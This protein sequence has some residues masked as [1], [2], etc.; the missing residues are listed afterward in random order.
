MDSTRRFGS[1]S[2]DSDRTEALDAWDFAFGE[3]QDEDDAGPTRVLSPQD[4]DSP[5]EISA[6]R[7]RRVAQDPTEPLTY[8]QPEPQQVPHQNRPA[9]A[10]TP[11]PAAPNYTGQPA[12]YS[13]PAD[14]AASYSGKNYARIQFLPVL[15]GWLVAYSLVNLSSYAL[16]GLSG[17]VGIPSFGSFQEGF[18]QLIHPLAGGTA[19]PGL[20]LI[21]AGLFY[22]L[23]FALGGYAAARMARLA[24]LKQGLGVWLWHLLAIIVSTLITLTV[25]DQIATGVPQL[26]L[27]NLFARGVITDLPGVLVLLVLALIG[28]LCGS[29]L[30]TRYHRKLAKSQ[31]LPPENYRV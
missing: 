11:N 12:T 3:G 17:L 23:S 18:D 2:P 7:P 27:Q 13:M 31:A 24:P 8:R 19:G 6:T 4:Q 14:H 26:G 22:L 9:S 20:W 28:S 1:E 16:A 15:L 21:L 29:A 5:T 25:A 10:P 30:G